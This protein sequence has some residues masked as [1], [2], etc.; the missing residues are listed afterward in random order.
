MEEKLQRQGHICNMMEL[1]IRQEYYSRLHAIV[2][3]LV[4]CLLEHKDRMDS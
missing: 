1:L 3:M 2:I 4:L